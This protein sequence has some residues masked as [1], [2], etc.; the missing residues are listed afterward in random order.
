MDTM[1]FAVDSD[2]HVA[3]FESGE[4]GAVPIDAFV[5]EAELREAHDAIQALQPTQARLDPRGFAAG[6][7]PGF[8]HA[9]EEQL[10]RLN[11]STI[12]SRRPGEA[13]EAI[14]A[15]V[16]MFLR[17]PAP[18]L[19]A[20]LRARELPAV[21]GICL[22]TSELDMAAFRA[23]HELGLCTRCEVTY[24]DFDEQQL[25]S[26]GLFH[27]DHTC[28]N[29]ISG[30]YARAAIPA[31]PVRLDQLPEEV[32]EHVVTFDGKF[33]D[34][35]ELQPAEHWSCESWEPGWLASDRKTVRP[36]AGHEDEYGA[37]IDGL[38]EVEP[39]LVFVDVPTS[40]TRRSE[41]KPAARK[42][43]WWKFWR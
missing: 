35:V 5:D 16:L 22:V 4:A 23:I 20:K 26:H 42:K 21:A 36:F 9:R 33:A 37:A 8:E 12:E 29:W 34:T 27:Y 6:A 7:L 10:E 19:V 41:D 1:W 31:T 30:P 13:P 32:R 43:P 24:R 15:T 18:D 17:E 40:A 38:R 25:A 11:A 2:G 28:D 3:V 14:K 39:D